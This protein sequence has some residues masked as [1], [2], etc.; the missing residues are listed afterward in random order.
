MSSCGGAQDELS[1]LPLPGEGWGTPRGHRGPL[2]PCLGS[3][4]K[5]PEVG[6]GQEESAW[7][8]ILAVEEVMTNLFYPER[9]L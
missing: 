8:R 6:V 2:C 7:G 1:S 5:P 3:M 4:G 9:T